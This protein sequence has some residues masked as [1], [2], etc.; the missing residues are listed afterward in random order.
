MRGTSRIARDAVLDAFDSVAMAA[1]A[2]GVLLAEQL[3]AAVDVLDATGSLRRALTDPGRD[4]GDKA[5]L[6]ESLFGKFDPRVVTVIAGLASA[7]WARATI[8]P[9]PLRT[10]A[11]SH[12]SRALKPRVHSLPSRTSC[13]WSSVSWLLTVNCSP[14]LVT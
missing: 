6:V 13:S 14:R 2:D 3:F 11:Y 1:G 12:S 9:P 5:S 10:R 7:R 8:S 4:G